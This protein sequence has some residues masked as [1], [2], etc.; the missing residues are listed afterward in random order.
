MRA[1]SSHV[2][3]ARFCS[4]VYQGRYTLRVN[5]L[6]ARRGMNVVTKYTS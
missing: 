6:V 3:G 5:D 4:L 1:P 2:P